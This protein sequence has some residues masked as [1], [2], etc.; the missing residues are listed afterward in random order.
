MSNIC[1]KKNLSNNQHLGNHTRSLSLPPLAYSL[2]FQG[3]VWN[4]LPITVT[5]DLICFIRCPSCQR[6]QPPVLGN[7]LHSVTLTFFWSMIIFIDTQNTSTNNEI[8][9][10]H[11]SFI[12]EPFRLQS[13]H[14]SCLRLI[15]LQLIPL[16]PYL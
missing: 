7:T 5:Y 14:P 11:L 9:F 4:K 3:S 1:N 16:T 8:I 6:V 10:T 13:H 15:T 2:D 12:Q